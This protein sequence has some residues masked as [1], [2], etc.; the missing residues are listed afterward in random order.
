MASSSMLLAPSFSEMLASVMAS[1]AVRMTSVLSKGWRYLPN[2]CGRK[3]RREGRHNHTEC[4][5]GDA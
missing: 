3:E 2:T 4:P 1:M 5:G